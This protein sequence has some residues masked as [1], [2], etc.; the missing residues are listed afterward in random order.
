MPE[1]HEAPALSRA[2]EALGQHG[3]HNIVELTRLER[4]NGANTRPLERKA[5]EAQESTRD[6]AILPSSR[7]SLLFQELT[8]LFHPS[9]VHET[10]LPSPFVRRAARNVLHSNKRKSSRDRSPRNPRTSEHRL[11]VRYCTSSVRLLNAVLFSGPKPGR[12]PPLRSVLRIPNNSR[13]PSG[14][15]KLLHHMYRHSLG[16]R[17]DKATIQF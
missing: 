2:H 1:Q 15:T 6:F 5:H 3:A 9:G 12:G 10:P 16:R 17:R 14:H 11:P 8:R 4:G 7:G 13:T